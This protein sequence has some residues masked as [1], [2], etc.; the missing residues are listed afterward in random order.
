MI[1][2]K[3]SNLENKWMKNAWVLIKSNGGSLLLISLKGAHNPLFGLELE[4]S[5]EL[6]IE[7]QVEVAFL[8]SAL[9]WHAFICNKFAC[10]RTDLFVDCN[11]QCAAI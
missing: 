10:L 5:R 4:L 3:S 2:L 8:T 9:N 11:A 7:G 6:N 1:V